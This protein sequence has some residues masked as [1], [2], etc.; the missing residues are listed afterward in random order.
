MALMFDKYDPDIMKDKPKRPNDPI[1]SK[2][3]IRLLILQ[4]FIF[5]MVI[6]ILWLLIYYDIIP[7]YPENYR[8]FL[9][10]QGTEGFSVW[11]CYI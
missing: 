3:Y 2:S 1:L 6:I 9:N 8:N 5:S 7:L 10:A 11:K 4:I